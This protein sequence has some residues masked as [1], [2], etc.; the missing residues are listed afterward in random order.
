M[1]FIISEKIKYL[2]EQS[3]FSQAELAKKLSISRAAVNAWEMGLNVPST[4]YVVEL[5]KIFRVSTDYLL[6]VSSNLQLNVNEL[7]DE[8]REIILKLLQYFQQ[9]N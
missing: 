2:R 1:I 7:S 3:G 4:K 8:E 6:D 9:K 5:A